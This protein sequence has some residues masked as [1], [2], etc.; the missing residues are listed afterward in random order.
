MNCTW[1]TVGTAPQIMFP[2]ASATRHTPHTTH[3]T[4]H[5]R[6]RRCRVAFAWPNAPLV[7]ALG[8]L[9]EAYTALGDEWDEHTRVTGLCAS[10]HRTVGHVGR[11]DTAQG[12]RVKGQG[13][14]VKGQ[15]SRSRVKGQG[16]RVKGQR[17]SLVS[18]RHGR[19]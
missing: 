13:S 19:G 4:P 6:V 1:D 10:L 17:A 2:T 9:E 3:H 5:A 11:G 16:S 15:G 8:A 18:A 12:S 7:E 14:R